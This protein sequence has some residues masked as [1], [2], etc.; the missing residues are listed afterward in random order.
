MNHFKAT[1]LQSDTAVNKVFPKEDGRDNTFSTGVAT[2]TEFSPL[3]FLNLLNK[4]EQNTCI[5]TGIHKHFNKCAIETT[6]SVNKYFGPFGVTRNMDGDS[7]P[8][9]FR[10][11]D[12]FTYDK[13]YN[14]ILHIDV[15]NKE[16]MEYL[17]PKELLVLLEDIVPE[18]S[19][20][21]KI[22][23]HS[24]SNV[25]PKGE[26][27]KRGNYH[28]YVVVP[29]IHIKAV[30]T[31]LHRMMIIKGYGH[32]YYSENFT[33]QRGGY[34][35]RACF[36]P[37]RI[38][39]TAPPTLKDDNLIYHHKAYVIE[40]DDNLSFDDISSR[41]SKYDPAYIEEEYQQSWNDLKNRH[42]E[43][44]ARLKAE[45]KN[46]KV[47]DYISDGFTPIEAQQLAE[48]QSENILTHDHKVK[49]DAYGW[50][51]IREAIARNLKGETCADPIEFNHHKNGGP[52]K[53]Q[54]RCSKDKGWYIHS[55]I[56]GEFDYVIEDPETIA[57]VE[58][59]TET[60]GTKEPG[61]RKNL[62]RTKFIKTGICLNFEEKKNRSAIQNFVYDS[63]AN[64]WKCC[65]N[66][67]TT[68]EDLLNNTLSIMSFTKSSENVRE[69]SNRWKRSYAYYKDSHLTNKMVKIIHDELV[70]QLKTEAKA[71]GKRQPREDHITG[72]KAIIKR[73]VQTL[74]T[75]IVMDIDIRP[76][77]LMKKNLIKK[78]VSVSQDSMYF[79]HKPWTEKLP[80]II[81]IMVKNDFIDSTMEGNV[82]RISIKHKMDLIS[83]IYSLLDREI[84]IDDSNIYFE[85][86]PIAKFKKIQPYYVEQPI[87]E[88]E[89]LGDYSKVIE[90]YNR[91]CSKMSFGQF[92]PNA[93]LVLSSDTGSKKY[94]SYRI[95]ELESKSQGQHHSQGKKLELVEIADLKE[96]MACAHDI[97]D[98]SLRL[99]RQNIMERQ[100]GSAGLIKP[101]Y[102][103]HGIPMI[104]STNGIYTDDDGKAICDAAKTKVM[105]DAFVFHPVKKKKV[106]T[107]NQWWV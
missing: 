77:M 67:F 97:Y 96:L 79:E 86:A 15:D 48:K 18:L 37:E 56:H 13:S 42:A 50:L 21:T 35:D 24:S 63:I 71:Q 54:L 19:H 49:F 100:G 105:I 91:M 29:M 39:Y 60:A 40:E 66:N 17:Q 61:T 99:V 32:L 8:I 1:V 45:Y 31:Y 64:S 30:G 74:L 89:A 25:T 43:E 38:I 14:G 7:L 51:T 36:S 107:E 44:T 28:I 55:M 47:K 34:V 81:K 72:Y 27:S 68:F 73:L 33:P 52:N 12:T 78:G 80:H 10:G 57:K 16:G 4:S 75:N 26:E 9:S 58:P 3:S 85:C 103:F 53:A 62:E 93:R 22:V 41:L 92:F 87:I 65:Q 76:N 106:L 59:A 2:T 83:H 101:G 84:K 102:R 82:A 20:C 94:D 70:Q 11:L 23:K 46:E 90:N 88:K 6:P 98:K 104:L 5:V 95:I 69:N